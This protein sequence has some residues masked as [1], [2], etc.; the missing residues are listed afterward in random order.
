MLEDHTRDLRLE[1]YVF[2]HGG[3]PITTGRLYKVWKKACQDAQ[4]NHISLQQASRHSRA[5]EIM[6]E[7]KQRALEEIS[8]QLGHDNLTTG[9]KHYVVEEVRGGCVSKKEGKK[10]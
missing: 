9:Q 10:E 7:Y 1:E 3:R 8:R 5:S 6:R 4:V 2:Q